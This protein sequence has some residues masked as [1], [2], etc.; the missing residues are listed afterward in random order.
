MA[1]R[2]LVLSADELRGKILHKILSRSGFDCRI[3][4]RMLET[5]AAITRHA[6]EIVILDTEG[7]FAGELNHLRH[8][9]QTVR[10]PFILV[11][12]ET[13]VIERFKGRKMLCL[14]DPID[15]ELI[16]SKAKEITSRKKK[17]PVG[18]HA[19]EKTLKRFLNLD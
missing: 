11:L 12:G 19:L 2:I 4:T 17:G 8:L 3:F 18:D 9:T 10:H 5:G 16:T 14:A 15:P 13:A 6:P 7:C 1:H